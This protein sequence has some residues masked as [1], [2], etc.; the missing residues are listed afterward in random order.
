[1][2]SATLSRSLSPSATWRAVIWSRSAS[3][4]LLATFFWMV[5]AAGF[6]GFL[7]KWGLRDGATR[8]SI[9]RMLDGNAHR[10][11]VY[12]QMLPIAANA[13]D[14]LLPDSLKHR[15]ADRLSPQ[16]TFTSTPGLTDPDLRF[17]YI[18]VCY[19]SFLALFA[20]LFVLRE[21]TL[22]AGAGNLAALVAPATL[23]LAL[24][25]LQTVGGYFYDCSELFFLSLAFLLAG[26]GKVLWLFAL[27]APA[28]LNKESFFFFIPA[29]YPLLAMRLPKE[30]AAAA[31]AAAML[32][33]GLVTAALE[34]RFASAAGGT[35]ELHFL[36]N[37]SL[38]ALPHSYRETELTYGI[39]GP[40]GS[41]LATLLLL[42]IVAARGVPACPRPI[43][44]HLL[45]ATAVNLPL[46]LVFGM[47]GELRNLSLLFVGL[48]ILIAKGIESGR[49]GV[50]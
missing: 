32:I 10:P 42:L 29:L 16:Q 23:V 3:A 19:L 8:F 47:A 26:R 46:F 24:P 17:R 37:L 20:C 43:R 41:S 6:S 21:I 49:E 45:I 38:Y 30:R 33:A 11:F 2:A 40:A 9:E 44:Q 12:R 5:A 15:L 7:G 35:T 39:I 50:Q 14:R 13:A 4:L 22:D 48:V 18:V 34:I 25:Y 1:M 31:I 27:A 36:T 28:A